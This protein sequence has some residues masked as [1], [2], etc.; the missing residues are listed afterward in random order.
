MNG[1]KTIESEVTETMEERGISRKIADQK[2]RAICVLLAWFEF[3]EPP[4]LPFSSRFRLFFS[5]EWTKDHSLEQKNSPIS[6]VLSPLKIDILNNII[7]EKNF[8]M[9]SIHFE[10]GIL[11]D[12][13]QE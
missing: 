10:T 6:F 11:E 7:N 4:F 12:W 13:T 2:R 9:C 8:M 1:E 3:T 5:S